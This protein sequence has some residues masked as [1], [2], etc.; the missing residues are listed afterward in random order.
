MKLGAYTACVHD[1]TL[2]ESLTILRDL[3]LELTALNCNGNPLHPDPQV[4]HHLRPGRGPG[5]G[6]GEPAR[7]GRPGGT[8]VNPI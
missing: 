2:E 3:G 1:K 5:V 7:G 4:H 6:R 8:R